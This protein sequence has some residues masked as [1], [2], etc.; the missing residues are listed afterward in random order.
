VRDWTIERAQLSV[1]DWN[2]SQVRTSRAHCEINGVDGSGYWQGS[3]N[4]PMSW[5]FG[6]AVT[7][8]QVTNGFDRDAVKIVAGASRGAGC[9]NSCK[10]GLGLRL[11][12]DPGEPTWRTDAVGVLGTG[13]RA[14]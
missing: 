7:P 13:R 11:L 9:R 3:L 2:P 8:D 1:F 4:A 6:G 5:R 12:D 10:N 14:H